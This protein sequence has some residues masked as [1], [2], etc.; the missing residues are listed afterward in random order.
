ML[1]VLVQT[2]KELF[3]I[4]ACQETSKCSI[5]TDGYNI[6]SIA[7]MIIGFIWL[8]SFG[9]PAA[10]QLEGTGGVDS[11]SGYRVLD[12]CNSNTKSQKKSSKSPLKKTC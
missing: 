2:Y 10:K 12:D 4:Q 3:L 11:H 5:I 9:V 1:C 7:C 8:F 6:E